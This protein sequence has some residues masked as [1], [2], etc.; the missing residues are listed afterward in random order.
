MGE[1]R[2]LGD[3]L[4]FPRVQPVDIYC[5]SVDGEG[6]KGPAAPCCLL[7][8]LSSSPGARLLGLPGLGEL[9]LLGWLGSMLLVTVWVPWSPLVPLDLWYFGALGAEVNTRDCR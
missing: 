6:V 2:H 3:L 4:P 1:D 5:E 8:P 7:L 9:A